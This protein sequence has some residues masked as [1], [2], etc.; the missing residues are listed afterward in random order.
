MSKT[1]SICIFDTSC[2][3]IEGDQLVQPDV[4]GEAG[5]KKRSVNQRTLV[6]YS[7]FI[8]KMNSWR[9]PIAL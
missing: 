4:Q 8:C 3:V 2:H 9:L 5:Q 1:V 6:Y 7:I